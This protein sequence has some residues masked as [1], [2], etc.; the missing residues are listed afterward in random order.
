MRESRSLREFRCS[1][2]V[3]A[4]RKGLCAVPCRVCLLWDKDMSGDRSTSEDR[5]VNDNQYIQDSACR[6]KAAPTQHFAKY[7]ESTS[8]FV[9]GVPA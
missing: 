6:K 4:G 7:I 3:V 5:S 9:S 1:Q 8:G 2:V